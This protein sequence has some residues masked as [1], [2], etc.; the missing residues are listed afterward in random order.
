MIDKMTLL[1]VKKT[2]HVLAFVTR[3]SDPET[4]PKPE[5]LAGEALLVRY[6]GD[7]AKAWFETAQFLVPPDELDVEVKDF[8]DL[9]VTRP[10]DFY[11]DAAKE[12][13]SASGAFPTVARVGN[14]QVTVRLAGNV[15]AKT[16]VWIQVSSG[17]DPTKTQIRE[18][19]IN[20][21]EDNS[22]LNLLPLDSGTHYVLALVAGHAAFVNKITVP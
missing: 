5:E 12:V 1:F 10:R 14:S 2:G 20:V 18:S 3:A 9:V 11:L 7:P 16:P 13:V 22:V 17:F 4:K 8:D 6:V 21:D 15:T 19:D